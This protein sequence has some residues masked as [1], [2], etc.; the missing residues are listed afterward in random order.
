MTRRCTVEVVV[1]VGRLVCPICGS[2]V[3][4]G[5]KVGDGRGR[6][7]SQCVSD[8]DHGTATLEDGS[9]V[10]IPARPWFWYDDHDR[11][12][13]QVEIDGRQYEMQFVK[14]E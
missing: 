10:V 13:V 1:H 9:E 12:V 2:G 7:W 11:A 5:Y 8:V 3:V 4:R 6:W 14:G